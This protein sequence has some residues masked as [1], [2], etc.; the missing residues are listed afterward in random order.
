MAQ[1]PDM[2]RNES[3]GSDTSSVYSG[4]SG[5]IGSADSLY[6]V[7]SSS[8]SDS[9]VWR[10]DPWGFYG[11]GGAVTRYVDDRDDRR[12]RFASHI[13]SG[14]FAQFYKKQRHSSSNSHAHSHSRPSRSAASS[15][16]SSRSSNG[17]ASPGRSHNQGHFQPRPASVEPQFHQEHFQPPPQFH[18]HGFQGP[19]PPPPPPM[20]P[21]PAG[22]ESGF[23]QLGGP[24]P[25]PQHPGDPW[26]NA[27]AYD[28][29]VHVY[30]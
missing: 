4:R 26:D 10:D 6:S 9:F 2:R 23:I 18:P 22:F 13:L 28:T 27:G 24:P 21:A 17:S 11:V 25:P 14:P 15:R 8:D 19:P 12:K 1:R 30:D 5:S 29:G 20:A 7:W 16:S 3:Y